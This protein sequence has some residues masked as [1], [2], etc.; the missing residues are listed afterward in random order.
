MNYRRDVLEL[1]KEKKTY[2]EIFQII[3]EKGYTGT[4]DA[5]RGYMSRQRHLHNHFEEEYQGKSIEIVGRKW[6]NKLFYLPIEKVPVIDANLLK[7]V[8]E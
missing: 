6:L 3:S 5:I 8:F 7:L 4:V 1:R 2:Q